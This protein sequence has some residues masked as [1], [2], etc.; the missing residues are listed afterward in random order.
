MI[1]SEEVFNPGSAYLNELKRQAEV[2]VKNRA[3]SRRLQNVKG[4]IKFDQFDESFKRHQEASK[5]MQKSNKLVLAQ[6]PG[7]NVSNIARNCCSIP[8]LTRQSS[9][10]A[11]NNLGNNHRKSQVFQS[12]NDIASSQNS[13]LILKKYKPAQQQSA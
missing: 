2:I 4:T 11:N 7:R 9:I 10:V 1:Q 6:L 13:V 3:F 8:P 5:L 12:T